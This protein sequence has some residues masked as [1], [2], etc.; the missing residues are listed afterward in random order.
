M[1]GERRPH[2]RTIWI[3][4][5]IDCIDI[6]AKRWFIDIAIITTR[7]N[8]ISSSS[9]S[10]RRRHSTLY[11]HDLLKVAVGCLLW[12][13]LVPCAPVAA[14][15]LTI[16]PYEEECFLI[17]THAWKKG[18]V[19]LLQGHYQILSDPAER[20]PNV[21]HMFVMDDKETVFFQSEQGKIG[22]SFQIAVGPKQ[23]FW[24]C[25]QNDPYHHYG[26]IQ[27]AQD[28]HPDDKDRQ[29]GFGY[30]IQTMA[31]K[32]ADATALD[33]HVV[34]WSQISNDMQLATQHLM[35][36]FEY[37]RI[38]ESDHRTVVEKT[39]SD[40]FMGALLEAAMVL[41]VA[42][43]QVFYFRRFLETKRYL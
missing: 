30:R 18:E 38:R 27:M 5:D 4:I 42:V 41:V 28:K 6:D 37:M 11:S 26:D 23:K 2:H 7:S 14:F 12:L 9:N 8:M 29:V 1:L 17:R 20:T 33:S 39:F 36:H 40:V 13:C 19:R 22:D 31:Q 10:R 15:I 16:A 21:V 35:Q 34:Q 25:V 32:A 3:D 43:G 24:L